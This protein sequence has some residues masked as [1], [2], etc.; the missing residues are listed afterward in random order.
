MTQHLTDLE[1]N[2]HHH[3]RLE[4]VLL[5]L[6]AIVLAYAALGGERPEVQLLPIPQLV[7]Q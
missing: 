2:A 3:A 4:R 7:A 1:A 6:L 5:T